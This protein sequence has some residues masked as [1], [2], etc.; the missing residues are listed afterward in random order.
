MDRTLS[1]LLEVFIR[2]PGLTRRA[3]GIFC[4]R[5]NF[6]ALRYSDGYR[7]FVASDGEGAHLLETPTLPMGM[8]TRRFG[9]D[10]GGGGEGGG[11]GCL[12]VKDARPCS[13]RLPSL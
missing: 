4:C 3:A 9:I 13:G 8:A 7:A 1:S 11:G 6:T 2:G 12:R 10:I 5:G